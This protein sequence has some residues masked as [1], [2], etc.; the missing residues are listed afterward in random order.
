[1]AIDKE[2]YKNL[3]ELGLF[4]ASIESVTITFNPIRTI[5]FEIIIPFDHSESILRWNR[6]KLIL[7]NIY[8]S[9]LNFI[10]EIYEYPE[11]S[12]SAILLESQRISDTYLRL[13]KLSQN[14]NLQLKE[15]YFH[16]DLG[17]KESE[18]YVVCEG[19]ELL[20][21]SNPKLLTEF[22]GFIK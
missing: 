16:I 12:R 5:E 20:I 1:M 7:K 19:H 11:F 10:N 2:N 3:D 13:N 9:S 18:I 4:L 17:N 21:D 8:W 22:E 14:D 6:G 15:Y